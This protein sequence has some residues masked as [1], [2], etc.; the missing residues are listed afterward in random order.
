MISVQGQPHIVT[1]SPGTFRQVIVTDPTGNKLQGV[2]GANQTSGL[3]LPQKPTPP[4]IT[5]GKSAAT[6]ACIVRTTGIA[7]EGT[8]SI[9]DK[10]L[11]VVSTVNS[12]HLTRL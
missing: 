2:A 12:T 5:I 10:K 11:P 3:T 7:V 6:A 1:S 4:G 9:T 8:I